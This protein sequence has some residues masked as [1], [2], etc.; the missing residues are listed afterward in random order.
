MSFRTEP[1][2]T[3]AIRTVSR[4][5]AGALLLFCFAFP[6]RVFANASVF[7]NPNVS[8]CL[9]TF[10]TDASAFG[11]LVGPSDILQF[12]GDHILNDVALGSGATLTTSGTNNI[13]DA[14]HADVVDFSANFTASAVPCSGNTQCTHPSGSDL[15]GTTVYGG[16]KPNATAVSSAYTQ[17]LDIAAYWNA[18]TTTSLP[19][20]ALSGSWNIQNTGTGVHVYNAASGYNPTGNVTIG[21]GTAGNATS[22]TQACNA[23]D[24]IVIIV[25]TGQ[26]ANIIHNI[27]FAA[28]SGL[29]DDQVLFLIN[30]TASNAL[31]INA[32]GN[33]TFTVHGDFF[34]DKG[35]GYTI[36]GTNPNNNTTID[37]RVF[38]GGGTG[39]PTLVWNH[40]VTLADEGPVPEP[41]TW[42]LMLGGLGAMLW[43][44]QQSGRSRDNRIGCRSSHESYTKI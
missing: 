17:F 21:C 16:T 15:T 26:T 18:Q 31:Q 22:V 7:V 30:G 10:C 37:G 33:S 38:A 20:Q 28:A 19:A 5:A 41:G 6:A 23:N 4:I 11:V 34:V 39:F 9:Y 8:S 3:H 40:N 32:T 43:W 25:P 44:H 1:K 14:T 27:T 12:K 24:L 2:S 29:T 42:A 13:G 35:G 36:G